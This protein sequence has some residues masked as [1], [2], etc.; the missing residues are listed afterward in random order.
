MRTTA[1]NLRLWPPPDRTIEPKHRVFEPWSGCQRSAERENALTITSSQGEDSRAASCVWRRTSIVETEKLRFE[2]NVER[3][4]LVGRLAGGEI[5][6]RPPKKTSVVK[7]DQLASEDI[8]VNASR[9][10]AH[11]PILRMCPKPLDHGP[12]FPRLA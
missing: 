9:D 3:D 11:G 8:A 10:H 2:I 7:L 5:S 12:R 4:G 1:K 6:P